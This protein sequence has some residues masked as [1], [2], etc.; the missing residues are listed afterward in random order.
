MASPKNSIYILLAFFLGCWITVMINKINDA[1]SNVTKENL[2]RE[3]N[4]Y[5]EQT[6]HIRQELE[7]MKNGEKNNINIINNTSSHPVTT[8]STTSS[9]STSSHRGE[10]GTLT[11]NGE[12]VKSEV[13][14]WRNVPGDITYESPLF[15]HN[16]DVELDPNEEKFIFFEYDNGGWNN[17]RMGVESVLVFAHATGRTLVIPPQQYLYLLSIEHKDKED[18]KAHGHMGFE[19]FFDMELLK[20][21][22]GLKII[23]S[24]DFL[25]NYVY[26]RRIKN[27]PIVS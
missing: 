12:E 6:A 13:I 24:E 8:T 23:S 19:D 18:E 21:H 1:K 22:H 16:H 26:N 15:P 14:Y 5:K 27:L 17:I 2:L 7:L 3:I 4:R 10:V 25:K 11:C 9:S 20:T